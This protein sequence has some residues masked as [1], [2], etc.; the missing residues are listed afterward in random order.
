MNVRY[1]LD[2]N[3]I[4]EPLRPRPNPELLDRLAAADGRMAIASI[5]WHELVFGVE[6]LAPSRRRDVLERYLIDVVAPTM[7][8]LDYDEEAA[9]W[10]ARERARLQLLGRTVPFAD[11]QIAAIAATRGLILVTRNVEDF[12]G[13]EGL[14]LEDWFKTHH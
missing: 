13:F 11:A 10:H 14:E 9:A 4:S 3:I 6:R 7:E 1:L 5:V 8:I 2:T 12:S